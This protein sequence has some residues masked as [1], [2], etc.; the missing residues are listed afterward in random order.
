MCTIINVWYIVKSLSL[1][2]LNVELFLEICGQSDT[3][4]D[5]YNEL[6]NSLKK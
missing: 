4:F 5:S 2:Q 1:I 6:P 3:I